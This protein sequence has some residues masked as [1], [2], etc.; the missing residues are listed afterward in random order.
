MRIV[1]LIV[2]VLIGASLAAPPATAALR[3]SGDLQWSN[4]IQ[5][6][7]KQPQ[8]KKKGHNYSSGNGFIPGYVPT[9]Y[10]RGDCIGW[11]EPIG[12]GLFR[13]RGQFIRNGY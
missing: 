2:S 12:N 6:A 11:W 3:P 13:C 10:G 1:N 8:K 9:P 7:S 4:L 5:V